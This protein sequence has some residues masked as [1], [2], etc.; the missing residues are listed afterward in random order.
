MA[1]DLLEEEAAEIGRPSL[2]SEEVAATICLQLVEGRS[3]RAICADET[4]PCESTVYNWL[5]DHPAFLERYTRARASQADRMLD[6]IIEIAD[7]TRWDT[8]NTDFGPKPNAEWINRSKLRVE[9]RKWAMA[10]LAPKKYG[11]KL[12]VT[13]GDKPL[14]GPAIF[15]IIPASQR[16]TNE[17]DPKE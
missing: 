1:D 3:V 9:A 13:S 15:Q 10:K 6:E 11:D 4:M 17:V 7:D 2:Y 14:G 16:P 12:D 8:E 5:H